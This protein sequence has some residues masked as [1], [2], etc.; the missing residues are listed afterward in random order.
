M[1]DLNAYVAVDDVDDLQEEANPDRSQASNLCLG[2]RLFF[3]TVYF[4]REFD[5]CNHTVGSF[6]PRRRRVWIAS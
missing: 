1:Y 4:L 2:A 6:Q 5:L 3:A